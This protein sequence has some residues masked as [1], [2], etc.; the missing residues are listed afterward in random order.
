MGSGE[1]KGLNT[2]QHVDPCYLPEEMHVGQDL[3]LLLHYQINLLPVFDV[4]TGSFLIAIE[5]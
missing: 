4:A 3:G 1:N 2:W 5:D